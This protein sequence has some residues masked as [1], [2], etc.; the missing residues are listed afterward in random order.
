[1][2]AV[3]PCPYPTDTPVEI[4]RVASLP[5]G[6]RARLGEMADVGQPFQATDSLPPGGHPPFRRLVA[7]QGRGCTLAVS[8]EQGGIAHTWPTLRLEFSGGAWKAAGR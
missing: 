7:A 5:A 8:Y 6:V 1:M 4:T 3:P 2:P